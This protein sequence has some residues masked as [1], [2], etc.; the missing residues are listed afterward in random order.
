MQEEEISF[1]TNGDKDLNSDRPT[2]RKKEK[3]KKSLR[4]IVFHF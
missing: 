4:R 1:V 2:E 3:R